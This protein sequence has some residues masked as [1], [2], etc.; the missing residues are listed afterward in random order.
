MATPWSSL[1]E[2]VNRGHAMVDYETPLPELVE[3]AYETVRSFN[4]R[5]FSGAIVAPE[6]YRILGE[7]TAMAGVFPQA[8]NPLLR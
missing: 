1:R 2:T 6:P 4:H 5:T 8:L 7:L 3:S